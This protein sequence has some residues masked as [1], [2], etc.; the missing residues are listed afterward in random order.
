MLNPAR[1]PTITESKILLFPIPGYEEKQLER[2][3]KD[4]ED[5]SDDTLLT[6]I[7]QRFSHKE[8]LHAFNK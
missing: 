2:I 5:V 3:T 1:K 8:I 4:L 7:T 6:Y